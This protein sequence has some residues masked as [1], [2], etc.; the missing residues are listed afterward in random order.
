MPLA[1]AAVLGVGHCTFHIGR[2]QGA[3]QR[4]LD[5]VCSSTGVAVS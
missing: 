2:E 1:F 5:P 3:A 4:V